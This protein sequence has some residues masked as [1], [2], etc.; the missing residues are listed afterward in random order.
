M[1]QEELNVLS[2]GIPELRPADPL[3]M[4]EVARRLDGRVPA[5]EVGFKMQFHGL[6]FSRFG[7][8]GSLL[9]ASS[10]AFC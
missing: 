6:G 3:T 10:S 1:R 8:F 5:G 9:A 2:P 7:F 4:E